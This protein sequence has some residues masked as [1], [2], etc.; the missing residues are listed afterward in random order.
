MSS[1]S[2]LKLKNAIL[3]YF[4]KDYSRDLLLRL[5]SKPDPQT[6][7][8][9]REPLVHQYITDLVKP[10]LEEIGVKDIT[11]D[12]NM[13]LI[14]RIRSEKSK[15]KILWLDYGM[16]WA[17][18]TMRDPF[19]GKIMDGKQF[20]LKGEVV[21]GRGVSEYKSCTAAWISALKIVLQTGLELPSEIIYVMSSGGHASQSDCV[22]HLAF[23]D[24]LTA[25]WG[26]SIGEPFLKIG[27][28]GRID[29]KL[30]IYG[31]TGHTS[32]LALGVNAIDGAFMAFEKLKKLMPNP[33]NRSDP[34]FGKPTLS[35][36]GIQSFPQSPGN[37]KGMG[38]GGHSAQRLVRMY[39][40]RRLLL[41]ET[42]DQAIEQ[43]RKT[44]G[45]IGYEYSLEKGAH[46]MGWKVPRDARPVQAIS[47]GIR[48]MLG[49]EPEIQTR[50]WTIDT[51]FVNRI[52]NIPC[53]DYGPMDIRFAHA[54]DDVVELSRVYDATKVHAYVALKGA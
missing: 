16:S 8:Y 1:D 36:V 37:W 9:E 50:K 3:K 32:D 43:V 51:G 22:A 10:E 34:D 28:P 30:N 46:H 45:D 29:I 40:D 4:D 25:D 33:V 47:E 2:K 21:R 20:G 5:A 48:I 19:V 24:H 6:E 54:D 52:M 23:N 27:N 12:D 44:I 41:D 15:G 31:K 38:S 53:V 11:M 17:A 13:N 18:G 42:P 26:V 39:L 7:L 14:A 49:R 35:V